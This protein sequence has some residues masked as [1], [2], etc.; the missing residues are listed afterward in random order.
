MLKDFALGFDNVGPL[1]FTMVFLGNDNISSMLPFVSNF[2]GHRLEIGLN[3][4]ERVATV[5]N[6]KNAAFVFSRVSN[7]KGEIR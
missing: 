7:V 3:Y 5:L 6:R 2:K 4:F 1:D